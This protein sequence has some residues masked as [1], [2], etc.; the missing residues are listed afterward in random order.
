[1]GADFAALDIN[2]FVR[3]VN[4]GVDPNTSALNTLGG[5]QFGKLTNAINAQG[6]ISVSGI[7]LSGANA[8]L[9]MAAG[10]ALTLNANP[11]ALLKSGGGT[12]IVN[13]GAGSTVSNNN[14]EL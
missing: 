1:N 8:A 4:P 3:P 12:S 13:G 10:A 11:G 6:A 2:G 9:N 5:N 14:Q 7:N